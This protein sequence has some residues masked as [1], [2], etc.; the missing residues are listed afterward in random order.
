MPSPQ[1]MWIRIGVALTALAMLAYAAGALAQD[2]PPP[3]KPAPPVEPQPNVGK[4]GEADA[5]TP[6]SNDASSATKRKTQDESV[7]DLI[8]KGGWVMIPLGLCSVLAVGLTIERFI[9]LRRGKIIPRDFVAGLKNL[10]QE[11]PDADKAIEFCEQRP[12]PVSVIFRAG[13]G[14]MDYGHAS[15]E[16]AIEDAGER[17]VYKMKRSLRPLSAI[18]T[19]APLL[20][21]LG[22][23]YGLIRAFQSAW[24]MG[25]GRG[26]TLARGIYE[27]LVTTATGL[28]LAIPVLIIYQILS[29]KVDA[30]VDDIDEHA[31]DL[32]EYASDHAKSK[33]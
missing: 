26:E 3:D 15:M 31:I 29:S 27:A 21:L 2:N 33:A 14:R 7:Y 8:L 28:T 18:A 11:S 4:A 6:A 9:G 10:F 30:L 24:K 22:T 16:K 12:S 5:P 23:V 19:I 17:E 25:M 32:L 20:G 1:W 13:I